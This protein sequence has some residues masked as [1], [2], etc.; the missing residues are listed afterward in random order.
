[1]H[2]SAVYH[3]LETPLHFGLAVTVGVGFMFI[4]YRWM[5]RVIP[6]CVIFVLTVN[7]PFSFD[8]L[9]IPLANNI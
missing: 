8:L 6:F 4:V 5:N 3:Y 7:V 1:M 2:Q 9:R